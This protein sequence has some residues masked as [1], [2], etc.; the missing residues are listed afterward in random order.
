[1]NKAFLFPGQGSQRVHMGEDLYA[2]SEVARRVFDLAQT[3]IPDLLKVCFGDDQ[4]VLDQTEYAQ[5]AIV[6]VSAALWECIPERVQAG[7]VTGH[8]LGEY[9][10]L[11]AAGVLGLPEVLQLVKE[12]GTIMAAAARKISGGM[13]AVMGLDYSELQDLLVQLDLSD[14]LFPANRNSPQQT[15]LSGYDEAIEKF[16]EAAFAKGAKTVRLGVSGPFHSPL[17]GEAAQEFAAVLK[18]FDFQEPRLPLVSP[19]TGCK[20]SKPAE[21]RGALLNQLTEPVK[22]TETVTWL[23]K[24][25]V[26]TVI[27]VGPGQ[28]LTGL[29][30]R[31]DPSLHRINVN[32]LHQVYSLVEQ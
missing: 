26:D 5:P 14:Q 22:W 18:E 9:S 16:S 3:V 28:V 7:Y 17:M 29:V 15:V 6:T 10:A 24:A 27:E 13:V 21:V 23:S 31:I 30:K 4:A 2:E 19:T 1:M 11:Y 32:Q 8:S 20:L 12:R 25:G